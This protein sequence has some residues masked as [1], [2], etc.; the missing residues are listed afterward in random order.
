M[1]STSEQQAEQ[2][3]PVAPPD[4]SKKQKTNPSTT[5][6]PKTQ[7][8]HVVVLH[9]DPVNTFEHVVR[10]LRKVFRYGGGKAFWLTLTAHVSGRSVVWTGVLEVA[11]LKAQQIR[12]CG[13]D[14]GRPGARP[15]TITIEPLPG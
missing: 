6:R 3:A 13:P 9:N 14:P 11:E 10:V 15:L 7:P 8:P 4:P 2:A 5:T 1:A 12:D